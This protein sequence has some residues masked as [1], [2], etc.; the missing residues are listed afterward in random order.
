M[1]IP[2]SSTLAVTNIMGEFVDGENIIGSQSGATF[3][4]ETFDPL[5]DPANKEVYDNELIQQE[6]NP[7]I[8]NSES[9]PFGTL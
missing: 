3:N 8:D 5:N 7:F 6:I 4:L 1:W 9:N 2:S